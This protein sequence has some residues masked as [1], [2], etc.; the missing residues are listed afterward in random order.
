ML[1]LLLLLL[2]DASVPQNGKLTALVFL[3]DAKNSGC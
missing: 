1:P 3:T 2:Q